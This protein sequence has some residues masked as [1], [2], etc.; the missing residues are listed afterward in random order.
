MLEPEAIVE[1][2]QGKVGLMRGSGGF[3]HQQHEVEGIKVHG[4]G[5]ARSQS[6]D[7]LLG[8]SQPF[9]NP[10]AIGGL[11][12]RGDQQAAHRIGSTGPR[13][14]EH[15]KGRWSALKGS[16]QGFGVSAMQAHPAGVVPGATNPG[17]GELQGSGCRMKPQLLG[18]E[19]LQQQ[20]A[21]AV[22]EGI[23]TGQQHPPSALG[24]GPVQL[25]EQLGQPVGGQQL[26]LGAGPLGKPALH[27][28]QESRW[29]RDQIDPE[30]SLL[31]RGGKA[32]EAGGIGAHH[33]KPGRFMDGFPW[34]RPRWVGAMGSHQGTQRHC[35][36]NWGAAG[37]RWVHPVPIALAKVGG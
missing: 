25:A 4:G 31:P 28:N 19:F 11:Q 24:A 35:T 32:G 2:E 18:R 36:M 12:A 37:F 17:E 6:P 27:L 1:A 10:A 29:G 21:D 34:L 33:L 7:P 15:P 3:G 30:Q 13:I 8:M 20:T 16:R 14:A 26:R 5:L 22:P 23:A 9:A